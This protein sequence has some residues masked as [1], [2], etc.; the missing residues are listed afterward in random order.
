MIVIVLF[1]LLSQKDCTIITL[2]ISLVN[3]LF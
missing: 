2:D 3:T 1:E